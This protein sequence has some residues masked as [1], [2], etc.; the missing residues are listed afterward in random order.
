R[1][2]LKEK[3]SLDCVFWKDGCLIY[4]NRPIQCKTY[5]FWASMLASMEEWLSVTSDCPGAGSGDLLSKDS[6]EAL[7][8]L[9]RSTVIMTRGRGA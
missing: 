7:A 8:E 2:S 6:I 9:D 3:T 1:L 4:Q 5:P